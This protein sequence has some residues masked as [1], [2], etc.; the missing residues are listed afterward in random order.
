MTSGAVGGGGEIETRRICVEAKVVEGE[1]IGPSSQITPKVP[2][3]YIGY[4][5]CKLSVASGQAGGGVE[6]FEKNAGEDGTCRWPDSRTMEIEVGD[7]LI[8]E[9]RKTGYE[10]NQV[11]A[12]KTFSNE[13]NDEY[14]AIVPLLRDPGYVL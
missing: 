14:T 1:R 3:V 8:V 13:F 2:T 10:T 9:A 11:F 6:E 7:Q 5:I 4:A 12:E